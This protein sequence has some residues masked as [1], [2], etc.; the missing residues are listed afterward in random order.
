MSGP[1]LLYENDGEQLVWGP[2]GP[3]RVKIQP[4]MGPLEKSNFLNRRGMMGTTPSKQ[5]YAPPPQAQATPSP[6]D[7]LQRA[8][9]ALEAAYSQRD[10][11]MATPA[12]GT[13]EDGGNRIPDWLAK[14][15]ESGDS[16]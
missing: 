12:L 4:E 14:Y 8:Q 2:N 9:A 1:E 7:L 3:E 6:D 11:Q 16:R 13:R 15:Q 10:A 5:A